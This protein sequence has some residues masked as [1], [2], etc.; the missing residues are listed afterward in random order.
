MST[1]IAAAASRSFQ[2]LVDQG[3]VRSRRRPPVEEGWGGA[4]RRDSAPAAASENRLHRAFGR[5]GRGRDGPA[6]PRRRGSCA[7][8]CFR[9]FDN[10]RPWGR[11]P[12]TRRFASACAQPLH[13]DRVSLPRRGRRPAGDYFPVRDT[14]RN[15]EHGVSIMRLSPA[16]VKP[17]GR[18]P[19]T[20]G[21]CVRRPERDAVVAEH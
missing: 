17:C 14:C 1:S 15:L 7:V 9:D 4:G 11:D 2:R 10:V 21:Q 3:A 6:P 20:S 13:L 19:A 5:A 12:S 16:D 18:V 8:T